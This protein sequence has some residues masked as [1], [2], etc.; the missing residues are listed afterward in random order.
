MAVAT[1]LRRRVSSAL[2]VTVVLLASALPWTLQW[3]GRQNTL[4]EIERWRSSKTDCRKGLIGGAMARL[5]RVMLHQNRLDLSSWFGYQEVFLGEALAV[6]SV[7]FSFQLAADAHLSALFDIGGDRFDHLAG[8][9]LSRRAQQPSMFVATGAKTLFER[10]EPL[11]IAL[12]GDWH[13]AELGFGATTCSLSVDGTNITTVDIAPAALRRIGFRGGAHRVLVDDVVIRHRLADGAP[14]TRIETFDRMDLWW[15]AFAASLGAALASLLVAYGLARARRRPARRALLFACAALTS[16]G[17]LGWALWILDWTW[18][19]GRYPKDVLLVP[20]YENTM[21]RPELPER[22]WEE[23]YPDRL[24]RDR[25]RILLLGGSQ[26]WGSG[27]STEA[28]VWTRLLE[29][30]LN[31]AAP[32]R[33]IECINVATSGATSTT[34]LPKYRDEWRQL[35]RPHLTVVNLGHNDLAVVEF[36]WNLAAFADLALEVGSDIVFVLEPNSVE[37]PRPH[38]GD[39]H[40]VMRFVAKERNAPV[41]D[42]P[43][44]FAD[45]HDRGFLWWDMVHQTSAGQQLMAEEMCRQLLGLIR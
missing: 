20:Q 25:Y 34:L 18:L 5:T 33:A 9:R 13:T 1:D 43:A 8:F 6:D 45:A 38:L 3:L 12:D 37:D 7:R 23:R 35:F 32:E 19:S 30:R 31:D 44:F 21:L 14:A 42:L 17:L 24:G 40:F 10:T 22:P 36:G 4:H 15:P 11:T 29:R 16:V 26:T 39:N 2:L 28:D 27:A 41:I